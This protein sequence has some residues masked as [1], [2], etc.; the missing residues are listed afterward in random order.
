MTELQQAARKEGLTLTPVE[1]SWEYLAD[2][3]T[4]VIGHFKVGEETH[5][6]AL[7]VGSG[8]VRFLGVSAVRVAPW[9]EIERDYTG[10]A[11]VEERALHNTLPAPL[12]EVDESLKDLGPVPPGQFVT[13]AFMLRNRTDHPVRV[14]RVDSP[15]DCRATLSPGSE[16]APG[17]VAWLS[18][19]WKPL[20]P[21]GEPSQ[22]RHFVLSTDHLGRRIYVCSLLAAVSGER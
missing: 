20:A 19:T 21:A 11:L 13:H 18:V 9:S 6:A 12:I 15:S 4:P 5:F 7:E 10:R 22:Q 1:I 2:L 17:K 8:W 16:I 3:A 14:A